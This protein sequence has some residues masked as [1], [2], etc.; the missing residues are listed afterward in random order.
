VSATDTFA[1]QRGAF[2]VV[3]ADRAWVR[4]HPRPPCQGPH[5]LS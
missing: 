4:L 3:G 1:E 2:T 5:A